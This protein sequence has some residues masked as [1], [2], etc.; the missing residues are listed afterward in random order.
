MLPEFA[1]SCGI[2]SLH[3]IDCPNRIQFLVAYLYNFP[4]NICRIKL[5]SYLDNDCPFS[6]H[7]FFQDIVKCLNM[8]IWRSFYMFFMLEHN[9]LI[10]VLKIANHIHETILKNR[11]IIIENV[12]E[13]YK[14]NWQW[15]MAYLLLSV[16]NS[17][18][19]IVV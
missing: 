7:G 8:F 4:Q 5:I 11:Q 3:E 16:L 12:N 10:N 13:N 15:M 6:F 2:V 19:H 18:I 17:K 9:L 1:H 14:L